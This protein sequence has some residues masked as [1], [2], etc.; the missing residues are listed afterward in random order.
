MKA[1]YFINTFLPALRIHKLSLQ[2]CRLYFHGKRDV[3]GVFDALI[4]SCTG[5]HVMPCTRCDLSRS[6]MYDP[7]WYGRCDPGRNSRADS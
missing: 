1:S 2:L 7:G 6:T 3:A 4:E 5:G